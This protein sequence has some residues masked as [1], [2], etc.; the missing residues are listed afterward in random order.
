MVDDNNASL[1]LDDDYWY[2]FDVSQGSKNYQFDVV[3]DKDHDEQRLDLLELCMEK[4]LSQQLLKVMLLLYK[5]TF[6]KFHGF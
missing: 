2:I 4:A 1:D 3:N 5:C 6:H